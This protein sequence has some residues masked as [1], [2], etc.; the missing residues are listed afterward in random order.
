M[1]TLPVPENISLRWE[2]WRGFGGPELAKSSIITG[3]ALVVSIVLAKAKL[4]PLI[5]AVGIIIFTFA[6]C[7]SVLSKIEINQSIVDYIAKAARFKKEQQIFVY[8]K[9]DKEEITLNGEET[10]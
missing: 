5:A 4:I 6:I 2:A 1:K 3:I 10:E 7:V 9:N 8:R